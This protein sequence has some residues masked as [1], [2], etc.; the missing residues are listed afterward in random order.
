MRYIY[1]GEEGEIIPREAT[2][3]T[4]ARDV[5]FVR[6]RAF[7]YHP[8]IFEIICHEDVEKIEEEAFINCT[9]L[10]RVVIPGVKE[11]E[12]MAFQNCPALRDVECDTLEI[13]RDS[14]FWNC[15][16][17]RSVSLLS[18]RIVEV[19][20]FSYAALTDVKFGSKLERIGGSAFGG[21]KSLERITIPLN[22]NLIGVD[23]DAIF[24]ECDNLKQVDLVEGELHE[25][26]AALHL[27]EWRNDMNEEIDSINHILPN[28]RAGYY[29]HYGNDNYE[30]EKA[31]VIRRWIFSVLCKIIHY[32]AQHQRLLNEAATQLQ[33]A[34]PQDLVRNNVFPLLELPSHSFEA[35]E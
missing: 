14:A 16:Y 19:N 27:E 24:I 33:L 28:A 5:T 13:I 6:A 10:R 7:E 23:D 25:T 18:A 29:N 26:I 17:L 9:F 15:E 4:V 32:Q 12:E 22:E 1:R 11:V 34:L 31:Y 8:N 21:C 30:G 35:E 20:A 2:H 3:I